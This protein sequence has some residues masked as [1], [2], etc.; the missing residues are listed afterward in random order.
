MIDS[1]FASRRRFVAGG[2]AGV[3]LASM[4]QFARAASLSVGA[5][6]AGRIDDGGFMEAG[7]RGLERARTE[8]GARTAYVDGVQPKR[9]LLV[10]ALARLAQAGHDL[11]V[12]HGGQNNEAAAEVAPRF[13]QVR[14][15]VT[16]G[17]VVGP[18]L[19]SY[20]VLQEESAYLAGVLAALTTRSGVVGHMSGIRVRPGLKGRAGFAAGVRDTDPK[21]RLLTNFSGQQD[22]NALSRRVALAEIAAGADVIFTM[23][24]AGRNGVTEAC[25]EKGARQIGNVIDWVKVDP[26]VFVASAIADVSMGVFNAVRDLRDG[27]FRPGVVHKVGVVDP[28]AVRLTVADDV[29]ASVR[30]RVDRAADDIRGGRLAVPENY[31]G[32]EFPNPA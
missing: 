5:L 16:Q 10:E 1:E 27:S 11:V 32:P 22:D 28:A 18:N 25:R 7:W 9:E 8:L 6:F 21:V 24:N 15:A 4:P 19:A 20:E 23:L 31:D 29:P 2:V 30:T 26:K 14:F 17:S 13:P 3:A 12:A